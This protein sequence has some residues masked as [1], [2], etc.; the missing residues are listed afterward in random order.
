MKEQYE[1]RK[2]ERVDAHIPLKFHKLAK[3]SNPEE[4]SI[5]RNFSQGGIC[6]RASEFVPLAK[7]LIL[8]LSVPSAKEPVKTISKV[9]WI[10]K[11]DLGGRDE[12]YEIG[13]QFLEMD[14]K[15]KKEV[16]EFVRSQG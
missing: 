12:E 8:S 3:G 10:R 5:S 15:D 6:F 7:R 2:E 14:K 13:V 4:G 16:F 1:K 9:A 11:V